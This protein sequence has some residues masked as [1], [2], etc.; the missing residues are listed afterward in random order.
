MLFSMTGFS[1]KTVQ[2]PVKAGEE[3][4][5]SVDMKS[6]NTRF[7]EAVCKLPQ[8]LQVL[9]IPI[10]NLLREKLVDFHYQCY[11]SNNKS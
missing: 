4:S 9:E 7:F 6:I 3:I 11:F 5:L 2:I 1:S 8:S 10:V